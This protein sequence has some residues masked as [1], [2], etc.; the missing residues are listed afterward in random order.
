MTSQIVI[1]N[2][3]KAFQNQADRCYYCGSMMWLDNRE[4]FAAKQNIS[5]AEAA[6]FKCTAEHLEARCD[7][8]DNSQSNIVAACLFCN[9]G[10]HHRKKPL[11]PN[12]YRDLI[13]NRLKKGKWHP[14]SLHHLVWLG[15]V[16]ASPSRPFCTAYS[17]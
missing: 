16:S 8:G 3:H 5:I 9:S 6:R 17:F 13:R 7:G 11:V 12:K 15:D 14:K 4:D 10:R 2:R 1:K